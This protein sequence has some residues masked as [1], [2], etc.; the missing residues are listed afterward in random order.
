MTE[1]ADEP[2]CLLKAT[3][4]PKPPFIH[5]IKDRFPNADGVGALQLSRLTL[6]ASWAYG[7]CVVSPRTSFKIALKINIISSPPTNLEGCNPG[8]VYYFMRLEG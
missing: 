6:R 4:R 2:V 1:T 5:P 8:C 7:A 3:S